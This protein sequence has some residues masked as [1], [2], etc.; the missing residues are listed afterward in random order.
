MFL[1]IY[2][3]FNFNIK[4]NSTLN[5]TYILVDTSRVY[6]VYIDIIIIAIIM[7]VHAPGKYSQ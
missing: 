3:T 1:Y 4:R 7:V 5:V 2:V 6:V